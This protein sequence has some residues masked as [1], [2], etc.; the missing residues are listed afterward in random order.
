MWEVTLRMVFLVKVCT[1][2]GCFFKE[3]I[4]SY[5]TLHHM[6][7]VAMVWAGFVALSRKRCI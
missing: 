5:A 3:K 7:Q 4:R 6:S 1:Q 2:L